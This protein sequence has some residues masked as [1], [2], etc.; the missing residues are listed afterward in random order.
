VTDELAVLEQS[1]PTVPP[2]EC[3]FAQVVKAQTPKNPTFTARKNGIDYSVWKLNAC[4]MLCRKKHVYDALTLIG[5]VS[6]KGG[7]LIKSVIEAAR[8]NGLKKGYAEE[9]MFVKE[10]VLG[11]AL[12]A[13]KIDIRARG[14]FGMMHAPIS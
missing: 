5:N 14:K 3:F 12:G 10:I 1:L 8:V 13:K 6:K 9:R 7:K 11:K 2:P 4:A